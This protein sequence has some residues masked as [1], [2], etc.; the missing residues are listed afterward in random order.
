MVVQ[1][2]QNFRSF[3]LYTRLLL[4]FVLF[5]LPA[6]ADLKKPKILI[7]SAERLGVF[8]TG[9]LGHAIDGLANSLHTYGYEVDVV[10]P[11]YRTLD[12]DLKNRGIQTVEVDHFRVLLDK[13]PD[14]AFR[15]ESFFSLKQIPFDE[16]GK[17]AKFYA[18]DH[19]APFGT[20]GYFDN[21][22]DD[23]KKTYGPDYQSGEAWGAFSKATAD[24]A[25][26]V[27]Y[28]LV[29]V[30]DWTS[31]L[32]PV[33]LKH[34]QRS[35]RKIPKIIGA[36]HNMGYQGIYPKQL[37]DFLGL[38]WRDFHPLHGFEF[39]DQINM[40]KA[41]LNFSDIVYTVSPTYGLEVGT[42]RFGENLEG[43]I[44][45]LQESWRMTGI[46]NGIDPTEWDPSLPK[47]GIEHTF[48]VSNME[49]KQLGKLEM[50]RLFGLPVDAAIPVVA[51]TSRLAGQK[52][53]EY[54]P[55]VI[56]NILK[57]KEVQFLI[58]GDGDERYVQ[59]LLALQSRYPDKIRYSRPFSPKK[60]KTLTAYSDFFLNASWYEPSGLN[61]FF[62][63]SNG[64]LPIVSR[65]GG[66]KD[67]VRDGVTGFLADIVVDSYNPQ[68]TDIRKTAHAFTE[69]ILRALNTYEKRPEVVA[70][71]RINAIRED[72][73]WRRRAEDFD[74]LFEFVRSGG[75]SLLAEE[76]PGRGSAGMS[77]PEMLKI[78]RREI[79][80]KDRVVKKKVKGGMDCELLSRQIS[81]HMGF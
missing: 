66:L 25:L 14:G 62:A 39:Y 6:G 27:G 53:Y 24:M 59:K 3:H 72:N 43:V 40:L 44:K 26:R 74:A 16:G 22:R 56:E 31:G 15:K 4:G 63:M 33:F 12:H 29:I 13:Q 9:G 34:A 28:D 69:T 36:I 55:D 77:P 75:P 45:N 37:V 57:E 70:Q 79:R 49:P 35:H 20:W 38:N 8:H 54:L 19:Y 64:T 51:L 17:K 30:N 81:G 61:Q 21:A 46:L 5:A 65:V 78:L 68:R 80:L 18:L 11:Y 23:G 32:V 42:K 10:T 58:I 67:S 60:E 52:G 2:N 1:A 41:M 47:P 7:V 50:Q 71:M 73:S 76:R 48:S